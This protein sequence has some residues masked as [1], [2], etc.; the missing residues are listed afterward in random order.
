MVGIKY[1]TKSIGSASHIPYEH[2]A[3]S[4]WSFAQQGEDLVLDRVLFAIMGKDYD[5]EGF[6]VDVGAYH[7]VEHSVTYLLY[8]RG[9]SGISIDPM[10]LTNSLFARFRPRDRRFQ[11]IVGDK[12]LSAVP[13]YIEGSEDSLSLNNSIHL[14]SHLPDK[15]VRTVLV[16][17]KTLAGILN[18][19]LVENIDVL[20]IDV[21][22]SELA[23]LKGLDFTRIR[24]SVI[25]IEIH[26]NDIVDAMT[27]GV[28]K[29]LVANRYKCVASTVITYFFVDL[30]LLED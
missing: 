14:S 21:E 9:W 26:A 23:V 13:F 7:P 19:A 3:Y 25:V 1:R 29:I 18:E 17:Q 5:Y 10:P 24:P 27:K 15:N 16:E 6:Y 8:R 22:G 11:T 4:K 12:E 30:D 2:R 20:N 28:A